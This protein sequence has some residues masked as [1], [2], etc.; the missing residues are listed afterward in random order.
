VAC[1]AGLRVCS[2]RVVSSRIADVHV[3]WIDEKTE[4]DW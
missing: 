4:R 3:S 2:D 1:A